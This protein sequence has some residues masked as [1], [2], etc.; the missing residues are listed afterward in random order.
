VKAAWRFIVPSQV[1]AED[2]RKNFPSGPLE[3]TDEAWISIL[4]L[5][6]GEGRGQGLVSHPDRGRPPNSYL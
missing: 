2:S 6:E 4:G 1:V 5:W 3:A